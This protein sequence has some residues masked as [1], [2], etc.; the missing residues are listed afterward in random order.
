MGDGGNTGRY[1]PCIY[2]YC[3]FPLCS[4]H[5]GTVVIPPPNTYI[6]Y[7]QPKSQFLKGGSYSPTG[8]YV[9]LLLPQFITAFLPH[10]RPNK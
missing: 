10:L 8:E 7:N 2:T 9:L 1:L 4:T 3:L 5:P 6:S